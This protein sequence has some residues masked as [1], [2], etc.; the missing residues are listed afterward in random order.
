LR[1][2]GASFYAAPRSQSNNIVHFTMPHLFEGQEG[3]FLKVKE[4]AE[5]LSAEGTHILDFNNDGRVNGK[6]FEL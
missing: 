6:D 4:E 3:L 2:H 5:K 1:V